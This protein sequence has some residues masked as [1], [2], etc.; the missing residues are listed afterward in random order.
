MKRIRIPIVGLFLCLAFPFATNAVADLSLTVV[1]TSYIA[2]QPGTSGVRKTVT[3]THMVYVSGQKVR[4]DGDKVNT[5]IDVSN[6][7][8]VVLDKDSKTYKAVA[9]VPGSFDFTVIDTG[10]RS[11][12]LGHSCEHYVVNQISPYGPP[13]RCDVLATTD[14]GTEPADVWPFLGYGSIYF[15]SIKGTPLQLI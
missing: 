8:Q 11:T 3:T 9:I 1:Q 2:N 5:I 7:Q 6:E 4:T 14:F 12:V 10:T 15:S 13:G